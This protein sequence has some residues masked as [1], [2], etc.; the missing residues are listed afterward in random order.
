MSSDGSIPTEDEKWAKLTNVEKA[1]RLLRRS[2]DKQYDTR[3]KR[4]LVEEAIKLINYQESHFQ[5][6]QETSTGYD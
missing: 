5:H 2:L 4:S 6:E 1:T 3:S